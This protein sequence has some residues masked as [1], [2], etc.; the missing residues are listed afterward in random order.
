MMYR[1]HSIEGRQTNNSKIW[2]P[3]KCMDGTR[4]VQSANTIERLIEL[5]G[6]DQSPRKNSFLKMQQSPLA[7]G[8]NIE[9]STR[10]S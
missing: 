2:H 3:G 1:G 4:I 10:K 8:H 6:D 5:I 9:R 7:A